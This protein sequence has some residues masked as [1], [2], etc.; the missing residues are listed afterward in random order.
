MLNGE[1]GRRSWGAAAVTKMVRDA[2]DAGLVHAIEANELERFAHFGRLPGGE[3]HRGPRLTWFLTGIP[4]LLFNGILDACLPPDDLDQHIVRAVA[5]FAARSLPMFWMTGPSTQPNDLGQHLLA[6]GFNDPGEL[7]GM[8]AELTT[9]REDRPAPPDLV[10][11]RV[12]DTPMLHRWAR[13]FTAGFG[14]PSDVGHYFLTAFSGLGLEVQSPLAHY[15]GLVAG[16]PVATASAFL[17]AGVVGIYGVT[18]VPAWQR[19]GIGTAMTLAALRDAQVFGYRFGILHAE[20]AG[21]SLYRRLGFREY[22]T[23]HPYLWSPA[24][25]GA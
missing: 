22:C 17:G 21:L 12:R 5:P 13:A 16:E 24:P 8:A 15:L 23:L 1:Y 9:L 19:K 7:V 11:E 18:T 3:F 25:A 4:Y 20:P 10:I 2:S 6:T 14:Y